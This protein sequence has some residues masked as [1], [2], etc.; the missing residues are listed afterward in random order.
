M[1]TTP[2]FQV[3]RRGIYTITFSLG[4][5]P[6]S[7]DVEIFISKN[8]TNGNDLQPTLIN[9]LLVSNRV[10]TQQSISW[11]GY[12]TTTDYFSVGGYTNVGVSLLSNCEL[13]IALVDGAEGPTGQT[14]VTGPTGASGTTGPT[15]TTGTT[16]P[17]GTTGRTGPTGTTGPTGAV[18]TGATGSSGPTG[19]TG[20]TG[21]LGTG[22]SGSTGPTSST[23]TTGSTGPT[24]QTG[25]T[26]STGTTGT[27]GPTGITGPTG[28]VGQ[29]ASVS[30]QPSVTQSINA[31]TL[32]AIK[33]DNP[34]VLQSVNQP[35]IQYSSQ[36]GLF[37]NITLDW[38]PLF[39]EYS[40][41]LDTTMGGYSVIGVNGTISLFGEMYNDLNWFSNSYTIILRPGET[42]GIYYMDTVQCVVQTSSRIR[43][44]SLTAGSQGPTGRTGSTGVTGATAATGPTGPAMTPSPLAIMSYTLGANQ[45]ITTNTDTPVQFDT[46]DVGMTYGTMKG[47]YNPSTYTFTNTSTLYQVYMVT[48]S[49]Y[50]GATYSQ[51]VLKIV[52]NGTETYGVSAINQ[53]AS[54][55]TTVTIRMAP[56][57]S[58]IVYYAQESGNN[59]D[60]LAAGGLTRLTIT[61]LDNV[62]GTTGPTG[63]T[64]ITGTIGYTG[65]TGS[66][67]QWLNTMTGTGTYIYYSQGNV[68]IGTSNPTSTL[69]VVGD[70]YATGDV[71]AFSDARYKTNLQPLT[72]CLEQV[73][74]IQGIRYETLPPYVNPS[75]KTHIGLLAQDVERQFPELVKTDEFGMKSLNYSQ[76]V[77]V[78]LECIKELNQR[79]ER[80]EAK[81]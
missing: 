65:P 25:S 19:T 43:L 54:A 5:T 67:S 80:L 81:E 34:D 4:A 20:P 78:L 14:G 75:H 71:T 57:D 50:T 59:Q 77:A 16:G 2:K 53:Q 63:S 8:L 9:Q 28:P 39:I 58:F 15:G 11:T 48:A 29:V 52:K 49:V 24:G 35:G 79:V 3:L 44:T 22:A 26:G 27:T 38:I 61:Q 7:G 6:S 74:D 32:T 31:S 56:N 18:G 46:L 47:V 37:T 30:Y 40:V 12:I 73:K 62:M 21:P 41:Q 1:G 70:I 51:S 68:G 45:T 60:L 69:H 13:T 55:T 36:T 76:M 33:W 17:T 23:G 10:F 72:N 42:V 64:G 66:S